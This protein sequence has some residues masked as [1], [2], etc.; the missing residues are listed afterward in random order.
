MDRDAPGWTEIAIGPRMSPDGS[1]LAFQAMV[2]ENTQVAVMKPESGNWL[3]LTHKAGAGYVDSIAWSSDGNRLYYDRSA[4]VPMGVY[5]VSAFGGD[6]Q[7]VL[8]DAVQ[9][10][11]LP[12]GS[13]LLLRLNADRALQLFRFWPESGRLQPFPL[14]SDTVDRARSSRLIALQNPPTS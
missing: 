5:S 14:V 11:P 4:D 1:T 6:E 8:E 12:D 7:M 9:P 2:G 3:V 13:L 10:E